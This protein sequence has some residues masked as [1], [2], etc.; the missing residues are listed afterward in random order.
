M[1][2]RIVEL[3]SLLSS[4]V[5]IMALTATATV[6]LREEVISILG[7]KKPAVIAI[8]PSKPNIMYVVI[9]ADSL[10]Q[11]FVNI[12]EGIKKQRAIFPRTIIY[13][14]TL[15]DCGCLYL[16]FKNCLGEQFTEPKDAPDLPEFRLVDMYHSC[17]DPDIQANILQQF[18][19]KSHLRIVIATVAFGMGIDCPD[20][21]QVIHLGPPDSI[22]SY[23]QETGRVGRDGSESIAVLALVKGVHK[24]HVDDKMLAYTKNKS[25][26]RRYELFNN[27]EGYKY[28]AKSPCTC[29]DLC[30]KACECLLCNTI[31]KFIY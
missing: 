12:M 20:V 30:G 31:D 18:C 23:I 19:K 9:Q 25:V 24:H 1:L 3:R 26:C 29:C 28:N 15:S 6:A 5:R 10:Q 14:Q 17:T 8:S 16:H 27:F 13:C 22:E 7:M 21:R 2:L 11:G 4:E